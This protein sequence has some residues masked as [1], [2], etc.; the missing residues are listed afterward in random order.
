MYRYFKDLQADNGIQPG[1]DTNI[2]LAVDKTSLGSYFSPS[3]ADNDDVPGV[4]ALDV[5]FPF[6]SDRR[7]WVA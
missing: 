6:Q 7:A 1:L 4:W 3:P 2:I 5:N